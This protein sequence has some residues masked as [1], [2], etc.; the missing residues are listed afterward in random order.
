MMWIGTFKIGSPLPLQRTVFL[1][2][3]AETVKSS[4][5][6]KSISISALRVQF[7]LYFM[8]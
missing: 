7:S 3:K 6:V 8:E 1:N 4:S 2:I 5:A